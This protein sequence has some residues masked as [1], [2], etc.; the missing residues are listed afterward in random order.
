MGRNSVSS[1]DTSWCVGSLHNSGV[2]VKECAGH[3]GLKSQSDDLSVNARKANIF[4]I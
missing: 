1:R 2:I 4:K 3:R